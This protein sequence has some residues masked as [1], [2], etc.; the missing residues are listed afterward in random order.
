[1]QFN[2]VAAALGVV[3]P[4]VHVRIHRVKL[5]TMVADDAPADEC[6]HRHQEKEQ[7]SLASHRYSMADT[8]LA[9]NSP[10]LSTM[11]AQTVDGMPDARPMF[12][13]VNVPVGLLPTLTGRPVGP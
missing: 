8:D 1:M 9:H 6:T 5:L 3:D 10:T 12:T 2:R 13:F 7:K 11:T 4:D